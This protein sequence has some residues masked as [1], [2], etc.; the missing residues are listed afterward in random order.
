[1]PVW[2]Q[3]Q[4]VELEP[5]EWVQTARVRVRARVPVRVPGPSEWW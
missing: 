4:Q 1:V 5:T 3:Q 2:A